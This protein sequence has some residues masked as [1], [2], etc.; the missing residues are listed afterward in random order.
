MLGDD[1]GITRLTPV[2]VAGGLVFASLTAGYPHTCGVTAAG[3]AYCWGGDRFG[4]LGTE[5]FGPT[6]GRSSPRSVAGGLVF[7]QITAGTYYT[8]GVTTAQLAYCWG[9]NTSGQLAD[10]TATDRHVPTRVK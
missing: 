10:W 7:A 1:T 6:E 3:I 2:P 9:H 4:N 5:P 8:C